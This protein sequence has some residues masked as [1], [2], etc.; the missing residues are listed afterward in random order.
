MYQNSAHSARRTDRA[1]DF[2][3]EVPLSY[4]RRIFNYSDAEW[5]FLHHVGGLLYHD[6]HYIEN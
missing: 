6:L 5:D 3:E 4:I 2:G 1:G